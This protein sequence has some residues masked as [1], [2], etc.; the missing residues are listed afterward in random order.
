MLRIS[1]GLPLD[2][3]NSNVH[4]QPLTRFKYSS[5]GDEAFLENIQK[6]ET[7]TKLNSLSELSRVANKHI[8]DLAVERLTTILQKCAS[9]FRTKSFSDRDKKQP[10]WYDKDCDNAKKEKYR[11]SNIFRVTNDKAILLKFKEARN[12][13]QSNI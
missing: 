5:R 4:L 3:M 6:E 13:I 2:A 9:N 8:I 7:D 1:H 10:V 11:W 12:K